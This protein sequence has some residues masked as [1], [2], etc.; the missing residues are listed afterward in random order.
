MW[1]ADH[2]GIRSILPKRGKN[3]AI[4]PRIVTDVS[5]HNS[6]K[7]LDYRA[8]HPPSTGNTVP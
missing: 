1:T 4:A 5:R 3:I 2:A 6:L 8:S 7:H